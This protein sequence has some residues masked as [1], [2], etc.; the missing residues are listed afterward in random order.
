MDLYYSPFACSLAAHI[1]TRELGIEVTMR[2]V[3]LPT[4]KL[5]G[6]GDLRRVNP[7]GQVPTLVLDDGRILTENLAVLLW[8]ADRRPGLAPPEGSFERYEVLKWCSFAATEL[9][10]K[11]AWPIFNEAPDAVKAH[12]R[13][14]APSPLTTVERHLGAREWLVGADFTVADAHLFWLLT[15]LPFGGVTLDGYPALRAYCERIQKRPAVRAALSFER[16]EWARPQG[17]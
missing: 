15:I 14:C 7:M 12:A 1:V 10:K 17:G 6:G 4:K 2:R 9:H 8:L 16:A 11:I 5:V 3:D 13:D